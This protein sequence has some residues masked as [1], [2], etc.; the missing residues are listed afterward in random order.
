MTYEGYLKSARV[1]SSS[2]DLYPSIITHFEGSLL[3][4]RVVFTHPIKLS[5]I[6]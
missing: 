4:F 6:E 5:M 3:S 1:V 2:Q